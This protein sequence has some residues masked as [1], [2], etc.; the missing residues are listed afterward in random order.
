MPISLEEMRDAAWLAHVPPPRR[1]V[2]ADQLASSGN[3]LVTA[4]AYFAMTQRQ[5]IVPP[6]L[7][8]MYNVYLDEFGGITP[9][10]RT[11][12]G[13]IDPHQFLPQGPQS[14]LGPEHVYEYVGG[15][16]AGQVSRNLTAQDVEALE[17]IYQGARFD[18][19]GE[20]YHGQWSVIPSAMVAGDVETLARLLGV[21]VQLLVARL[22]AGSMPDFG[23]MPKRKRVIHRETIEA[24]PLP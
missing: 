14:H 13:L 18:V 7:R 8:Q 4:D 17:R 22:A 5:A 2:A 16:A 21:T 9:A 3:S 6:P 20:C 11:N 15:H 24:L 1:R 10:A 19:G 12:V 23:S